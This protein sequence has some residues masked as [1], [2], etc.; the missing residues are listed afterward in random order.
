MSENP[1]TETPKST[2]SPAQDGHSTSKFWIPIGIAAATIGCGILY[3]LN[4]HN[5]LK[6]NIENN[7]RAIHVLKTEQAQI[8]SD[9]SF[10]EYIIDMIAARPRIYIIP[11]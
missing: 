7:D 6:M 3:V 8:K 10:N 1:Q 2:P 5:S 9:A 11:R 4:L